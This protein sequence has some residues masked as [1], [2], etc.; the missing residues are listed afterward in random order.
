MLKVQLMWGESMKRS[1]LTKTGFVAA[2]AGAAVIGGVSTAL[3]Q[4]AIP[5]SNDG[6]VHACYRNSASLTQPKGSLKVI[7]SDAGATCASGETALNWGSSGTSSG[8]LKDGSG[9]VL[10][11]VIDYQDSGNGMV[12]NASLER[13]IDMS[14]S[15]GYSFGYRAALA[16]E[17]NDCSGQPYIYSNDVVVKTHLLRWDNP[18]NPGSV[19]YATVA[20]NAA[21]QTKTIHSVWYTTSTGSDNYTCGQDVDA[22]VPLYNWTSAALPFTLPVTTPFKF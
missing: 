15:D 18:S 12:Y 7:D 11:A 19:V 20:G 22:G 2:V 5:S 1:I 10:G 4:A 13:L 6:Q 8:T 21:P 9:Q 16:F 3:V 14:Q 17:S